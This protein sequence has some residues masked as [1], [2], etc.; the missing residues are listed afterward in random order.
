MYIK[1]RKEFIYMYMI[2]ILILLKMNLSVIRLL[3]KEL[4]MKNIVL[5]IFVYICRL[6]IVLFLNFE[7]YLLFR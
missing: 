6:F 1:I 2:K 5:N 4:K 7:I 3:K